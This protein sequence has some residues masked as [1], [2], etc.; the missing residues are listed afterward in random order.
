MYVGVPADPPR[1]LTATRLP[2][3]NS[4]RHGDQGAGG[5]V[6]KW[7]SMSTPPPPQSNLLP[8]HTWS[9]PLTKNFS[10]KRLSVGVLTTILVPKITPSHHHRPNTPQGDR[11]PIGVQHFNGAVKC[12]Q[13][14]AVAGRPGLTEPK[15]D[16]LRACDLRDCLSFLPPPQ[17]RCAY[18]FEGPSTPLSREF[19]HISLACPVLKRERLVEFLI[20][21][22]DVAHGEAESVLDKASFG[23][24]GYPFESRDIHKAEMGGTTCVATLYVTVRY[25]LVAAGFCRCADGGV[26]V[27]WGKLRMWTADVAA[28]AGPERGL[29]NTDALTHRQRLI[30]WSFVVVEVVAEFWGTVMDP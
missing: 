19:R 22:V 1:R 26:N 28:T 13:P 17:S 14:T 15:R 2:P 24:D 7:A 23:V 12:N 29:H 8:A 30:G 25:G 6:G 18:R 11:G 9:S 3:K 10:T 5:G 16:T 4:S 21:R 27:S 20:A